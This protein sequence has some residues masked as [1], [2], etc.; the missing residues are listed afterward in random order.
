[1]SVKTVSWI[2]FAAMTVGAVLLFNYWASYES[3]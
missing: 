3:A 1:M 2:L